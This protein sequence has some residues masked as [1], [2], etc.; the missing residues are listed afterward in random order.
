MNNKVTVIIVAAGM[1]K[2]MGVNKNKQYI[3]LGNKPVLAHTIEKFEKSPLVHEIILIIKSDELEYCKNN[4]I[5][6]YG[7]KKVK[8]IVPGGKERQDS[9][10]NGIK[11]IDEGNVVLVHDG[12]R[13]FV[14]ENIIED[15]IKGSLKY[16]ACVVGV[17]VKD[18]IKVVSEDNLILD[19]P[20]RKTLWQ[21]QTPQA[22][23]YE[24]LKRAYD[25]AY[26]ENFT[27][28]DDASLV[29][30]L[31]YKVKMIMGNYENIKI[32]TKEDLRFADSLL[33]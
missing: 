6:T 28:T 11:A 30:N 16:N 13:P 32:T 29:E 33:E 5:K 27:G 12:A 8:K 18:T 31:G 7:F 1:G 9:V 20:N 19:T 10:Y 4:I 26:E 2:R 23:K 21:V 24:I 17:P 14:S 25:K 22:F 3:V 15:S